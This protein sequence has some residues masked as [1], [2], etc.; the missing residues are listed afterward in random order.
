MDAGKCKVRDAMEMLQTYEVVSHVVT[1]YN[2]TGDT[3]DGYYDK[4]H[5]R[6]DISKI[7]R[8]WFGVPKGRTI[9]VV[10]VNGKLKIQGTFRFNPVDLAVATH[11]LDS[12]VFKAADRHG[13]KVSGYISFVPVDIGYEVVDDWMEIVNAY[14]LD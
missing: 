5:M 4:F 2:P 13:V 14:V 9:Y 8:K 10:F 6:N 12:L 7:L 1:T 11:M 3:K